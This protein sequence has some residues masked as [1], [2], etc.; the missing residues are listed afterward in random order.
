[1]SRL[2]VAN[3]NM[4]ESIEACEHQ[5]KIVCY[6]WACASASFDIHYADLL[7]ELKMLLWNEYKN[8]GGTAVQIGD[9]AEWGRARVFGQLKNIEASVER[10]ERRRE[11]GI[12]CEE[13]DFL[14]I[15]ETVSKVLKQEGK[16]DLSQTVDDAI[17]GIRLFQ[18]VSKSAD[19][20]IL[21]TDEYLEN[22]QRSTKK[23]KPEVKA[24]K[25][26]ISRGR[27]MLKPQ[28]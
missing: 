6:A 13:Y 16:K 18:E 23:D 8:L 27:Q 9:I 2:S 20:R 5:L 21:K 1:M 11:G 3:L 25:E 22:I 28:S 7:A 10:A 17:E 4:P 26:Q 19:V 12:V 15:L 14:M 24:L